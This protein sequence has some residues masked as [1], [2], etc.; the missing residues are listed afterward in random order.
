MARFGVV[1]AVGVTCLATLPSF[2]KEAPKLSV[3]DREVDRSQRGASY[4]SAIKRATPSVVTIESIRT[5]QVRQPRNPVMD[6]PMFRRFFAPDSDPTE[7]DSER[8]GSRG[9]K[10][11][12]ESMGSGVIVTEDGYILTNNHVIEGADEDGIKVRMPD[13]KTKYDAK[14]VGRDP[15]TDIAVLKVDAQKKLP[16]IT[17]AN[18]E[19]LEVGDVVLA[20]GNPFGVGQSVSSGI[21]SALG[22][23]FGMLGR[24]GYEDFIQTDASINKGNSGGALVD[25]EGRLVGINQ[26]IFSPSGGNAGVGF[27]VPINMARSVMERL[28]TDGKIVR[29]FLGVSLQTVTPELADAFQLSEATG[30]LVGGVQPNTPAAKAGMQAGDVI[31]DYNGKAVTDSAHLRILVAQTPPQTPVTFKAVRK[32]KEKS[33]N[34]TLAEL[35]DDLVATRNNGFTPPPAGIES[36]LSGVETSDLDRQARRQFNIPARMTGALVT[37][38]EEDSAAAE[39]GLRPG[40]VIVELNHKPV[41]NAED[42]SELAG[43]T[44]GK[45]MLLQVYSQSGGL[46]TTRF[47]SVPTGK[48]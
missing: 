45:N 23:G 13:G 27:A 4:A 38:V 31:I 3:S 35:P 14:V 30:A 1:L 10:F 32:G 16:A 26:S 6:D 34:V 29:G 33:F 15:Q 12:Q 8:G 2:A 9:R 42:V 44:K 46:G 41:Q 36:S 40:D 47:L 7:G 19:K 43:D 11:S 17:L 39:A 25:A 5:I 24:S 48:K 21:V 20:V 28:V 18:S 22:R 37:K